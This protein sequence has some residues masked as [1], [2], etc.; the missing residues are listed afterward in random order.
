MPPLLALLPTIAAITGIAGTGVGLGMELS[1]QPGTPKPATAAPAAIDANAIG[2]QKNQEVSASNQFPS[3]QAATG[4]ALS[5]DAW[6]QLS[7]LLTGSA[8]TPGVSGGNTD[9]ISKI[10]NGNTGGTGVSAGASPTP[11]AP[12]TSG[13]TAGNSF[14]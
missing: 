8:G 9:L 13:L 12:G 5:P 11:P 2:V 3:I 10:L 6:V 7:Q 1:N 4:G 14:G